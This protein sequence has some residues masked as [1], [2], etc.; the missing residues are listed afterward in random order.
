MIVVSF[1]SVKQYGCYR[2][3]SESRYSVQRLKSYSWRGLTGSPHAHTWSW[4]CTF[5]SPRGFGEIEVILEEIHIST[6]ITVIFHTIIQGVTIV[7]QKD[8][9]NWTANHVYQKKCLWSLLL[10]QF[11]C[12]QQCINWDILHCHVWNFCFIRD[13]DGSLVSSQFLLIII[14]CTNNFIFSSL[15]TLG[16]PFSTSLVYCI[17]LKITVMAVLIE[18]SK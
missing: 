16:C 4:T 3:V 12:F 5:E 6:L 9:Q 15:H 17:S 18:I 2:H 11:L 14:C 10:R 1:F 7:K 13:K 8:H